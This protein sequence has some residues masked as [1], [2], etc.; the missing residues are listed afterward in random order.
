MGQERGVEIRMPVFYS[1]DIS[2]VGSWPTFC[3]L[4][5]GPGSPGIPFSII[6]VRDAHYLETLRYKEE[7]GVS[8]YLT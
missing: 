3:Y 8:H 1:K 4:I 2:E 7:T 5:L 6:I